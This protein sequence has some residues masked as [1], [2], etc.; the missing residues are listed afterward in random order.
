MESGRVKDTIVRAVR[1]AAERSR[2]LGD[3][4]SKD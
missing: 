4:L 1:A 3:E 2:E